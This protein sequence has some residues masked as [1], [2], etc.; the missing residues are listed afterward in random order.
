MYN[1]VAREP[2]ELAIGSASPS[3]QCD[4]AIPF[5]HMNLSSPLLSQ[6]SVVIARWSLRARQ[7][8][9]HLSLT[10]ERQLPVV[11]LLAAAIFRSLMCSLP[12]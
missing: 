4:E 10:N 2:R 9:S 12:A 5:K 6:I 11:L 7:I 1:K 8:T 3:A